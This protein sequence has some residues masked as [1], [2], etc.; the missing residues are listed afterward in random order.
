ME[1]AGEVDARDAAS[2]RSVVISRQA[3]GR[4]EAG[5]AG[6]AWA[7]ASAFAQRARAGIVPRPW[8]T[9]VAPIRLMFASLATRP[10]TPS[11][12][13]GRSQAR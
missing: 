2:V 12:V 5:A 13:G 11:C 7:P 4:P 8:G 3:R 1:E 10:R 6:A 9:Y